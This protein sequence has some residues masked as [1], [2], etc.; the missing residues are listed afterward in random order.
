MATSSKQSHRSEETAE[1]PE[2]CRAL[3]YRVK[4]RPSDPNA[5]HGLIRMDNFGKTQPTALLF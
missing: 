3:C 2:L 5:L 4:V 1:D